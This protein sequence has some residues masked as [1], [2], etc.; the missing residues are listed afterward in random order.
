M[1]T[2]WVVVIV[3]LALDAGFLLGAM[4]ASAGRVSARH[5]R[6]VLTLLNE[7]QER[8]AHA[9]AMLGESLDREER[10]VGCLSASTRLLDQA[11]KQPETDERFDWKAGTGIA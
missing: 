5:F 9:C 2:F 10:L 1:S 4:W 7:S 11:T 8:E 6:R 3:W